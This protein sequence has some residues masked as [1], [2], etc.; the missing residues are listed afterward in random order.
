MIKTEKEFLKEFNIDE[1]DFRKTKIDFS[2]LILIRN[3]YELNFSSYDDI[4]TG[5]VRVILRF[6]GV[7]SVKYRV[8]NPDHLIAKLVR[9]KIK[10]PKLNISI[11][12]YTTLITDIIGVRIM[13]LIK[14]DWVFIHQ[15]INTNFKKLGKPEANIRK[16]DLD[17]PYTSNG[18]KVKIHPDGYRSIHYLIKTEPTIRSV[19]SEI[20]VRTIFE[21]AW[22]EIDHKVRYPN[23]TDDKIINDLLKIFNRLAGSAD[24]MAQ[25][26]TTLSSNHIEN[27]E[28]KIEREKEI[29][30]LKAEIF[31]LVNKPDQKVEIEKTIDDFVYN[32]KLLSERSIYSKDYLGHQ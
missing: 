10:N 9:K 7:H 28:I 24:E 23:Q 30:Q 8:K 1:N 4:G 22:S 16:G 18:C 13:H 25:F 5:L 12:N 6:Q 11:K 19:I 3:N 14:A 32:S 2:D 15:D 31:K 27:K 20:Q 17:Q 21:E 26:V 29:Y